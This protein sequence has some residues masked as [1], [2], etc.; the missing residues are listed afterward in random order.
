MVIC[1]DC[2]KEV[3]NDKFCKNCG[4]YLPKIE[5]ISVESTSVE[6]NI[7]PESEDV[8]SGVNYCRNCGFKLE[9]DFKFCPNCGYN[10]KAP[11]KSKNV[12]L[13]KEKNTLLAVVLSVLLPGMGH[14]YLGLDNTGAILLIAYIVSL[15]LILFVIGLALALIVW[16]WALVDT[17]NSANA[18]NRGEEVEDKLF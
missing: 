14:M 11:V 5:E 13:D 18:L 6:P 16:V 7:A 9:G 2:G 8:K 10:L 1:P 17:I 15:I 4:A 12:S 3:P